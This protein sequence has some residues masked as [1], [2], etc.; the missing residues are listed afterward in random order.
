VESGV[1]VVTAA[2]NYALNGPF[3]GG[4][5]STAALALNV[6]SIEAKNKPGDPATV[7]ITKGNTSRNLTIGLVSPG[8]YSMFDGYSSGVI[9]AS[10]LRYSNVFDMP[11]PVVHIGDACKPVNLSASID[12]TMSVLLV[13]Q[14]GCSTD[15]KLGN[16]DSYSPSW[17]LMYSDDKQ[18]PWIPALNT[19]TTVSLID[20]QA[21]LAMS[22]AING[23]SNVT[24]TFS[25]NPEQMAISVNN[26]GGGKP[27]YFTQ[28]GGLFDLA[29][30]PDVAGL[31]GE[32]YSTTLVYDYT[33]NNQSLP[34]WGV[35][36]GTSMATPYVAGIAALILSKYGTRRTHG[37]GVARR[38]IQRIVS[39]GA[40]VPWSMELQQGH[41]PNP[42]QV[43]PGTNAPV[44]Q[45]GTGLV[46]AGKAVGYVTSLLWD[47]F[48]LNDTAHFR[49]NHQLN[50]TNEGP[51][52]V[53]YSF[54]H[55]V[56][57]GFEGRGP[58]MD[59]ATYNQ[60]KVV[61]LS[62]QVQL[63]GDVTIRPGETKTVR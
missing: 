36:N 13:D 16:L 41:E 37:P 26:Q 32:I 20:R 58:G 27:N 22:R 54:T 12:L 9:A 1:V 10:A 51:V 57:P 44:T 63:P 39:S 30:K 7:T 5:G 62:A 25:D 42:N 18:T 19:V 49:A 40:T 53:K 35:K 43:P 8:K 17:V 52:S 48:A 46:D 2:G 14:S 23:G 45:V 29:A 56:L 60:I 59:M 21:G 3:Y 31:G 34:S 33:Y 50:I 38:A 4:D 15:Q 11:L 6:A 24:I 55:L 47:S 61:N 28:W